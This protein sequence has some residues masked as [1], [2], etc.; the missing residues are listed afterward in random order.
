MVTRYFPI[1]FSLAAM[2]IATSPALA[3]KGGGG[4]PGGGGVS[5]ARISGAHVGGAH[6]GSA[7][8]GG[9]SVHG[10]TYYNHNHYNNYHD[11]YHNYPVVGFGIGLGGYPYLGSYY[12]SYAYDPYYL[13]RVS[14]YPTPIIIGQVPADPVLPAISTAPAAIRV[15][16]PDPQA[17]VW[18]DSTLTQQNGLDRL[19][20]TPALT[21]GGNYSYRIRASWMAAG[22]EVVQENVTQVSPG[23]TTVVDF[24]KPPSEPVPAPK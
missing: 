24:T 21:P 6:V 2:L 14:Y 22:K 1:T 7:H 10:G 16:V 8:V 19:F 5:A 4:R 20:H 23:Q 18:F 9:S 17:K 15:I 3:Q 13:P 11:H 12:P